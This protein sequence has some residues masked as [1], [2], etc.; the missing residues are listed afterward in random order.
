MYILYHPIA[1][2]RI[3]LPDK[4]YK[5]VETLIK[6]G[7]THPRWFESLKPYWK[8]F[9]KQYSWSSWIEWVIACVEYGW[10]ERFPVRYYRLQCAVLFYTDEA[11]AKTPHCFLETRAWTIVDEPTLIAYGSKHVLDKLELEA[12]SIWMYI[13][14]LY[15]AFR[16]YAI[17]K[18][19]KKYC[20]KL[21]ARL[22]TVP[23]NIIL[24]DPTIEITLLPTIRSIVVAYEVRAVD[25]DADEITLSEANCSRQRICRGIAVYKQ[26]YDSW[27]EA[28]RKFDEGWVAYVERLLTSTDV[29]RKFRYGREVGIM[30]FKR[31]CK[32]ILFNVMLALE[33][34]DRD[35][36]RL[37][38]LGE[39]EYG[40][41][42]LRADKR[43]TKI[44][45][46]RDIL[47]EAYTELLNK[48]IIR[49]V[50]PDLRAIAIFYFPYGDYPYKGVDIC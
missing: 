20:D 24:T 33:E 1:R 14:S 44:G 18:V 26:N 29:I 11:T 50:S 13:S 23:Y 35:L 15:T 32:D 40:D 5:T 22:L 30:A 37:Y 8:E 28:Y 3:V 38:V 25:G 2:V 45:S 48:G 16:E 41:T 12:M 7:Y 47:N 39:Y 19:S 4:Y 17:S 10:V 46:I 27:R 6:K 21:S 9:Y 36:A 43:L 42:L 34:N 49:E 31:F